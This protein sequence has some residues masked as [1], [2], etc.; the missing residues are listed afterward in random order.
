M[1]DALPAVGLLGG[2]EAQ[3][4][5]GSCLRRAVNQGGHGRKEY[6][7]LRSKD[8]KDFK[9]FKDGKDWNGG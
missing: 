4:L 2:I 7:N 6:T 5:R 9:D 8:D 3:R 1:S